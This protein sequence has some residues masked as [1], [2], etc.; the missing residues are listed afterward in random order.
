MNPIL[1]S[2]YLY[3]NLTDETD[4]L[5]YTSTKF[6]DIIKQSCHYS[7]KIVF[8]INDNY[9]SIDSACKSRLDLFSLP[10]VVNYNKILYLDSD[11]IIT[12]D[13]KPVFDI[14]EEDIMYA[15]EEGTIDNT[16]EYW[17]IVCFL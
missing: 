6:K 3:G 2:I 17:V 4:I 10:S 8:E 15:L 12:D 16:C 14:I 5:I 13:I 7:E 9:N 11:I 1:R